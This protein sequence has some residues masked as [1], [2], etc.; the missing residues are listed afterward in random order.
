MPKKIIKY[1]SI[2]FSLPEAAYDSVKLLAQREEKTVSKYILT[3]VERE[4]VRN[5]LPV[6]CTME[7]K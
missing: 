7:I 2:Q 5:G 4:I 3:L 1:K 6:F